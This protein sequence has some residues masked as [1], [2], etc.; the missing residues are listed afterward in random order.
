MNLYLR[1]EKKKKVSFLFCF[2]LLL[3]FEGH[4]K[5]EKKQNLLSFPS[6]YLKWSPET[7]VVKCPVTRL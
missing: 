6:L 5:D 4:T 1:I 2:I 3:F 7:E